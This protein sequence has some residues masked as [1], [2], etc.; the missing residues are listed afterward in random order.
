M[1]MQS[2]IHNEKLSSSQAS[3]AILAFSKAAEKGKHLLCF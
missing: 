3:D 2:F 1:L